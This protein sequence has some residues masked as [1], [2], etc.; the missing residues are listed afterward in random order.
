MAG[1]S[2]KDI[3]APIGDD[4]V[5]KQWVGYRGAPGE[6]VKLPGNQRKWTPNTKSLACS[7]STS[8]REGR[9]TT[10]LLQERRKTANR[11]S[12]QV[13]ERENSHKEN[14]RASEQEELVKTREE[15]KDMENHHDNNNNSIYQGSKELVFP[16]KHKVDGPLPTLTQK[17]RKSK[18]TTAEMW[19]VPPDTT[20]IQ[21]SLTNPKN[22]VMAANS[23]IY[24]KRTNF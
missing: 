10:D 3:W 11:L 9:S 14:R 24:A 4:R 13:K 8:E 12:S 17:Q 20:E 2:R 18:C 16:K 19:E 23:T 5:V 15:I 6:N 7:R 1:R 21:R 22:S